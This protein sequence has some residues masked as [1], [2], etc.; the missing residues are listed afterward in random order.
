M[1]A[2]APRTPDPRAEPAPGSATAPVRVVELPADPVLPVGP[3]A[4][5]A[6][7]GAGRW[8]V[9][10]GPG[11]DG[12]EVLGVDLGR[13]GGL[14]VVGG[15]GTGRTAALHALAHRLAAGGAEVGWWAPAG[16]GGPEG[17]PGTALDPADP[18]ALRAWVDAL[19]GR[20][21]VL[22][23]DDLGAGPECA[24][25]TTVPPTGARSGVV[26]LAAGSAAQ[27][28]SHYQGP[29]AA[30]RR[31]RTGLLLGAGPAD[32]ELLGIRL[33]R[34]PLPARPGSGWLVRDGVAERVQVARVQ[35][36]RV[37]VA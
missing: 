29:V 1:P 34:L 7:R 9:P 6:A 28:S 21:G 22:V 33:P 31:A 5:A 19:D 23:A 14:L 15:P 3:A 2:G 20:P 26:V 17:L 8:R 36:A 30:L 4:H 32:A 37:R 35:V 25:L 10:V 13:S 16:P 27:L 24:G 18:G 11:G 12:G